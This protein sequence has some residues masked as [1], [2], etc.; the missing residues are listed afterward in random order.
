MIHIERGLLS[1]IGDFLPKRKTLV[2]TDDGVPPVYAK[3]VADALSHATVLVVPQGEGSKSLA[4]LQTVLQALLDGHFTR[5]DTL[6][7]VGGGVVTD[8]GGL[9]AS[10]FGRG[11]NLIL[12]PTTVLAQVDAS[13]GGKNAVDFGGVK[14]VLGTFY[15]AEE[16]LIDPALTETLPPRQIA[17]GLAEAIK[18]GVTLDR[19]LFSLFETGGSYDEIVTRAVENK[20]RV[21]SLDPTDRNA[22]RV[23]NFG[24]TVGHA[25]EATTSLSHGESVSLGMLCLSS[26]TV[27]KRLIPVLQ[28]VGL[29]TKATFDVSA[30]LDRITHDKKAEGDKIRAIFAEEIGAYRETL[31]SVSEI[32]QTLSFIKEETA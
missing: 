7:A 9:A 14:N 27:R 18:M 12:I 22:R 4:T 11:M 31:L 20:S 24:H 17:S 5:L 13:V 2:L 19:T 29:P 15:Q 25:L 26:E 10:L 1:H 21:V 28:N 23:L 32:G 3:T 16:V 30:V 8:L 6:V